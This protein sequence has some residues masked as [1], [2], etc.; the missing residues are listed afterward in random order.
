MCADS[1]MQTSRKPPLLEPPRAP[2]MPKG[3]R[4]NEGRTHGSAPTEAV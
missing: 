2:A 1:I 4:Q 3:K